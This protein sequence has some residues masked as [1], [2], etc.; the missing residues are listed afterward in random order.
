MNRSCLF[1]VYIQKNV[2]G[3]ANKWYIGKAATINNEM[4]WVEWL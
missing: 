1:L 2:P 3:I 4:E